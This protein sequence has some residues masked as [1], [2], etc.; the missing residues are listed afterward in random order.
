MKAAKRISRWTHRVQAYVPLK[1]GPHRRVVGWF[2]A[3][4]HL[5][6]NPGCNAFGCQLFARQNCV[7]A[8]AAILL[9]CAHLIV[10]PTEKVAFLVMDSQ[11]VAQTNFA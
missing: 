7:D 9:K 6:I 5:A 1:F 8:Q 3:F 2:F 11:C 4:A 10:P